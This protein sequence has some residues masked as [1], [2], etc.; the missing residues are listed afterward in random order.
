MSFRG[1]E[2]APTELAHLPNI[3]SVLRRWRNREI[4]RPS[5]PTATDMARGKFGFPGVLPG[6][7]GPLSASK[8]MSASA[9]AAM[10]SPELSGLRRDVFVE[11][12]SG[13]K[14]RE[15][16]GSGS[17]TGGNCQNAR[18]TPRQ[19]RPRSYAAVLQLA[20]RCALL[21]TIY[22]SCNAVR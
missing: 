4:G 10:P 5:T 8:A 19:S 11:K 16:S 12:L 13:W 1:E 20:V 6:D 15:R 14:Q 7:S 3:V 22:V 2:C 9:A 18:L 17:N 21:R